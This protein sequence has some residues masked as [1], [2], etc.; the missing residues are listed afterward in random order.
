MQTKLNDA[1]F[2]GCAAKTWLFLGA[3]CQKTGYSNWRT[4]YSFA[5]K[6]AAT[7]DTWQKID[8]KKTS[9]PSDDTKHNVYETGNFSLLNLTDPP[10]VTQP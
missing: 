8:G 5:Y 1:A 4:T 10:N 3:V 6:G 7:F 2:L 9:D